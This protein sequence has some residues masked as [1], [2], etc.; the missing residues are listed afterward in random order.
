MNLKLKQ[1]YVIVTILTTYSYATCS[2][3]EVAR[4]ENDGKISSRKINSLCREK[5]T[6]TITK[7]KWITPSKSSCHSE[8]S[9]FYKGI[10]F[11]NW[12]K[13]KNICRLNNAR[14][15]SESE[16]RS[17]IAECGGNIADTEVSDKENKNNPHY[18]SCYKRKGFFISY[19]NYWTSTT[20][21]EI[22]M[23]DID[24]SDYA[25]VVSFYDGATYGREKS[26]TSPVL[27][28]K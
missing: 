11:A 18:Q 28:L 16:L 8:G 13:A 6:S 23:S 26:R 7:G 3:K 20:F 5:S 9:H 2:Q 12:E 19:G 25:T 22:T 14:L 24:T 1:L 27:C 21:W 15:P 10:C 4:L 17:I